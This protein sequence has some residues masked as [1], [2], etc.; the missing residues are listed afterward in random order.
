MPE[1]LPGKLGYTF[2]VSVLDA[3]IL[4]GI[5]I[6]W[7]RRSVFRLMGQHARPAPAGAAAAPGAIPAPHA[8]DSQAS[9]PESTANRATVSLCEPEPTA[10]ARRH[11]AMGPRALKRLVVAY[12]L[13]AAA[14][15]AVLAVLQADVIFAS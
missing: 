14:H 2:M 5:V 1:L 12:G 7:Y 6:W 8:A 15:A 4:S 13:G 9:A 11:H 3:A 10:H